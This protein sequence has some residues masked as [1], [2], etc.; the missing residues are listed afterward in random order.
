MTGDFEKS[1]LFFNFKPL[2]WEGKHCKIVKKVIMSLVLTIT[3]ITINVPAYS[4]NFNN[5]QI[6]INNQESIQH[7]KF[8]WVGVAVVIIIIA[9]GTGQ[10]HTVSGNGVTSTTCDGLGVCASLAH[11][12]TG[13]QNSDIP[14]LFDYSNYLIGNSTPDGVFKASLTVDKVNKKARLG[15]KESNLSPASNNFFYDNNIKFL[16]ENEEIIISNENILNQ[17]G[18]SNSII[19]KGGEYNVLSAD[20]Y[21]YIEFNID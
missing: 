20:G 15:V 12:Y 10:K 3:L 9:Y 4:A 11:N 8:V 18:S 5:N 14:E 16:S 17:I 21:K 13:N 7:K 19:L 2:V 6:I 1:K